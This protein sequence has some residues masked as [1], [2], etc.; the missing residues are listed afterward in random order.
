MK[1]INENNNPIPQGNYVPASRS[2]DLIY[3]AGMTPRKNG[4]LIQSGKVSAAEP[5]SAYEA[6]VIQA[7]SNALTAAKNTF[8]KVN[9]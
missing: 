5:I 1:P 7:V 8:L 6:A 2:R 9:L 3:T 4:V